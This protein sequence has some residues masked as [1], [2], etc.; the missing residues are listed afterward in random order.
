[1]T[2][3]AGLAETGGGGHLFPPPDLCKSVNPIVSRGQIM[4]IHIVVKF[5]PQGY[6]T[7]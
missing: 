7:N 1:M 2:H 6:K 3:W 4:P 5:Q